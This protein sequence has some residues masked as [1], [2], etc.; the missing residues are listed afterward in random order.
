MAKSC[1]QSISLATIPE[2]L[3]EILR[4]I[5]ATMTQTM[6]NSQEAVSEITLTEDLVLT[7]EQ[8]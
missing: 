1:V 7:R 3:W 5:L 8:N 6:S 4:V 2:P